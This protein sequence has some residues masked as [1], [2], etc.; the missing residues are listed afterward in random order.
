MS[1]TTATN[2]EVIK[3]KTTKIHDVDFENLGFGKVY[4][5]HMM[6]C[7][8]KNGVWDMPKIMPYQAITLAPSAKIFHY[9]QS[10][11]EGMKGYKDKDG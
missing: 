7:D 6:V 2:L 9:G 11:F 4:T 3:S 1:N 5:D 8:Y 10:I